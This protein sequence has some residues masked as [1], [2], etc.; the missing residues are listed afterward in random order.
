MSPTEEDPHGGAPGPDE[1]A[2]FDP[3]LE[4]A[5]RSLEAGDPEL[6]LT[7][8]SRSRATGPRALLEVRAYLDLGMLDAA[9]GRLEAAAGA[10]G[11]DDLEVVELEGEVA[12]ESWDLD[13]AR[14]AFEA[15][16]EVDLD[17]WT[18]ER[19]A[20]LADHRGAH[21]E[22]HRLLEE[23]R[24][25][26]PGRPAPVRVPAARFDAIVEAALETLAPPF[27]ERVRHVRVV[28]EPVP[29]RELVDPREPGATPPD[30][31]G[32]FVGPTIHDL[33]E[34]FPAQLPPSIYLFQRNLE[35]MARDEEH[36]AEEIRVTLFHEIGHLLGLDEDGVAE[37]GLA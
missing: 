7:E 21:A 34:D 20:L 24:R 27:A 29:F 2:A 26:D 30:I 5:A 19:L 28:R 31:L 12:L 8:A 32:L 14:R 36:L 4:A 23:A 10:L 3:A 9:R 13:G 18:C 6:A 1:G 22:A 33:A 17:P 11:P 25:L 16:A 37:L 35:R 15:V